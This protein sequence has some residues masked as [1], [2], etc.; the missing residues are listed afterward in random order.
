M[1]ITDEVR[2]LLKRGADAK[3]C[4]EDGIPALHL[5]VRNEHLDCLQVLIKDGRAKLDQRGP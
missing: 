1:D 2:R 4:N 3:A 5:A